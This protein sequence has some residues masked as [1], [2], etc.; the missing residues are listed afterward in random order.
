MKHNLILT[1]TVTLVA[2]GLFSLFFLAM[3]IA[4]KPSV[5]FAQNIQT[6]I[7]APGRIIVYNKQLLEL[8]PTQDAQKANPLPSE[9]FTSLRAAKAKKIS[10]LS[11]DLGVELWDVPIGQEEAIIAE[12]NALPNYAGVLDIGLPIPEVREQ[13][14]PEKQP[15]PIGDF[16]QYTNDPWFPQQVGLH[17][18]GIYLGGTNDA[19]IDA[20]EAWQYTRGS[21]NVVVA[22]FDS[23]IDY[24]HPDLQANL[25][26]NRNEIP[27]NGRDDDGNG[28]V[29]DYYGWN[30]VTQQG[31][32]YD[33]DGHGTNVAG[34]IGAVGNNGIGISGVAQQ[35]S[36]LAIKVY[37]NSGYT[38]LSDRIRGF[39]YI[40]YLIRR[41][42]NIVALNQS[43]G[44]LY[45]LNASTKGI[46][47]LTK[48]YALQHAGLNCIWTVSAGNEGINLD[49]SNNY[50]LPTQVQA[51]NI[52]SVT[53]TD[54]SDQI[55]TDYYNYGARTINIA[56]PGDIIYTT[57]TGGDYT[58]TAGTSFAAPHVAGVIALAADLFPRENYAAR[59]ARIL[60]GGDDIPSAQNKVSTNRRLNAHKTV[61]TRDIRSSLKAVLPTTKERFKE[62]DDYIEFTTG[63]VNQTGSPLL[64]YGFEPEGAQSNAFSFRHI[65]GINQQLANGEALGIAAVVRKETGISQYDAYLNVVTNRGFM[66]IN[67]D[68][69][70]QQGPQIT[71]NPTTEARSLLNHQDSVIASFEITNPGESTL[72]Y[73]IEGNFENLGSASN[74]S[75][76][77]SLNTIQLNPTQGSINAGASQQISLVIPAE[78]LSELTDYRYTATISSNAQ[79]NPQNLGNG[80]ARY[81]LNF[82]TREFREPEP[83]QLSGSFE[84]ADKTYDATT[85]A[86]L[87]NQNLSFIGLR[88]GETVQL[89][90]IQ[91]AFD[92]PEAGTQKTVRIV[93]ADLTGEMAEFYTLDLTNAPVGSGRILARP[94]PII[95]TFEVA[96][97]EYDATNNAQI[98]QANLQ[99]DSLLNNDQL[100]VI[101][102]SLQARFDSDLPGSRTAT[103]TYAAFQGP[104]AANY[105]P[106]FQ[107]SPTATAQIWPRQL[108]LRG[109]FSAADKTYDGTT[110]AELTNHQ[111]QLQGVQANH[112][113]QIQQLQAAF[114]TNQ[115]APNQRVYL[116]GVTLQG[117]HAD[118]YLARTDTTLQTQASILP[119]AINLQGNLQ[120]PDKE[121][122]GT[123]SARIQAANITLTDLL[124]QDSAYVRLDNLQARFSQSTPAQNIPIII[125]SISLS[126]QRAHNYRLGTSDSLNISATIYPRHLSVSGSFTGTPKTYDG[127]TKAQQAS[128]NLLLGRL[129][130]NHQLQVDSLRLRFDQA[131]ADSA[132]ILRIDTLYFSGP[133]R[134][135]YQV[136]PDSLPTATATIRP[137]PLRIQTLSGSIP[138]SG[139]PFEGG[140]GIADTGYVANESIQQLQGQLQYGGQAQGAILPGRYTLLA[141][142]LE[143]PNYTIQYLPG[144]LEIQPDSVQ[145]SSVLPSPNQQ[146]VEPN[147]TI[148]I[149]FNQ[150]IRLSNPQQLQVLAN[151]QAVNFSQIIP[152]DSSL[153][154]TAALTTGQRVNIRV[155]ENLVQNFFDVPNKPF[156][157]QFTTKAGAPIVKNWNHLSQSPFYKKGENL[158][159]L[160]DQPV[161]LLDLQ[162]IYFEDQQ[163]NQQFG[164]LTGRILTDS[165]LR[166]QVDQ[167]EEGRSYTTHVLPGLV[168][169]ADDSLNKAAQLPLHVWM[170]PPNQRIT[171]V[172]YPFRSSDPRP[173]LQWQ[174]IERATHYQLQLNATNRNNP[175]SVDTLLSQNAFKPTQNLEVGESYL[176]RVRATSNFG[177]APWSVYYSFSIG[178]PTSIEDESTTPQQLQ[179]HQNYPNPFNPTTT[180][181]FELP[182]AETIRLGIYS[183]S[184]QL[185]DQLAQGH[186]PAGLHSLH[187]NASALPSGIY[188]LQLS[189]PNQTL[190]RKITLLK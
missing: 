175:F 46:A 105:Q 124:P 147:A 135:F 167:L 45:P 47:D 36:L 133:Q 122:D 145:V 43:L 101:I 55:L 80:I 38:F 58:L 89:S 44:G 34:I 164:A 174:T 118:I 95:G 72:T 128:Q 65:T 190:I 37:S 165:L 121:Y 49:T 67:L 156:A 172:N 25:W 82:D 188:L 12:V 148:E 42:H 1:H 88:P 40:S 123:D 30:A 179:L 109:S 60:N 66:R 69:N 76:I 176:W 185:L 146:F 98:T 73:S 21:R 141:F 153:Q 169:N 22:I 93:S 97:K 90:N 56:A 51:P 14:L 131:S 152:R 32:I 125:E 117:Q 3:A 17:N 86:V 143:S 154:F 16:L 112:Q 57:R 160:F 99:P 84:V 116:Q 150:K 102:D 132:Q 50:R 13:S 159:L 52:L 178:Q 29:D 15:K 104:D 41:G 106:A 63:F 77:E 100:S 39:E 11:E 151:N 92:T 113:V 20:P 71:L 2:Q 103:L 61:A 75:T 129:L 137:A 139:Q 35:V 74:K 120:V 189:T 33:H 180:I 127:T 94:I 27:G 140:F 187:Y 138:Y 7:N 161:T 149:H 134:T 166:L 136:H 23:G 54:P 182:Q 157:W 5:A 18:T 130:P 59:I 168:A 87:S 53:A 68:I 24:S 8:L 108:T 79:N 183:M 64:V 31:D 9:A 142:G 158:E 170:Q 163:N 96:D 78:L 181:R 110:L 119:K 28:Y 19:D 81:T 184:G 83:V 6:A 126:G 171:Q 48:A 111:L 115:A 162:Y 70:L 186:M 144:S 155:G 177:E 91:L 107:Q 85:Q 173:E 62:I 26:V 4:L 10:T 114:A